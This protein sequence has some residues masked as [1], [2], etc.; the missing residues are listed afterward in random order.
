MI[1]VRSRRRT[2]PQAYSYQ[3]QGL[4][5][6]LAS[7]LS[8]ALYTRCPEGNADGVELSGNGYS[9]QSITL[10]TILNLCASEPERHRVD[11]QRH[12]G[13]A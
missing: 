7:S 5:S 4:Q 10:A 9:R 13:T 6:L 2:V 12:V 8:I 11:R 1:K 3:Q